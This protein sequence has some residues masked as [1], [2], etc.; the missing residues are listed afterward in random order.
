[1][2]AESSTLIISEVIGLGEVGTFSEKSTVTATPLL[3]PNTRQIQA[4]ADTDEALNLCGVETVELVCIKAVSN[5][6]D[7][8]LN[9]SSSFSADFT[10]PAGESIVITKPIGVIRIKN[11]DSAEVVTIDYLIVGSA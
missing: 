7:I 3:A 6:V 11:N 2:A 5:D 4:A 1:M 9:Y 8:D 10:I